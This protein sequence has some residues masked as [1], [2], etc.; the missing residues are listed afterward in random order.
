MAE[1]TSKGLIGRYVYGGHYDKKFITQVVA[2]VLGGRP[3]QVVQLEY[4]INRTTLRRWVDDS[5]L[6]VK[7]RSN[8]RAS[9]EIKR[10]VVRSVVSGRLSIRE[11]QLAYG[12][13]AER[14]IQGWIGQLEQENTDL[15][16]PNDVLMKKDKSAKKNSSSATA[17]VKALQKA[18]EDAQL[19]IAALNTLIDVAEEQLKINIR[20]K[21]GAK[22]SND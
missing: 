7:P 20:K 16:D 1:E 14:T 17:E 5:D 19:K 22:Q 9:M 15:V 10:S 6:A 21:P 18:L 13:K 12:V 2:E 8:G 4:G 3:R 11:A